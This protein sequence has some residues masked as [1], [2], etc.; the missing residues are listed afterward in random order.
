VEVSLKEDVGVDG[1][2]G[3][4]DKSGCIRDVFQNHLLQILS[5]VAMDQPKSSSANHIRDAKVNVL[6]H[7]T[8]P[9]EADEVVVGQYTENHLLP[10]YLDDDTVPEDSKTETFCQMVLYIDNERWRGVPFICR[11]GKALDEKLAQVR[12]LFQH[13]VESLYPNAPDSELV[14]RI[15][16]N[17]AIYFKINSKSPGLSSIN[18]LVKVDMNL[19]YERRFSQQVLIP[20]AY[21]R[22]ILDA[23]RGEQVLFVRADEIEQAW[24]VVDKVIKAIEK[25]RL[26]VQ[27]YMRGSSGP[28]SA[29]EVFN[30]CWKSQTYT[31]ITNVD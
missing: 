21:T 22:L 9:T 4:Y 29:E 26:K 25:G 17:K 31:K 1:R 12:I 3:Y 7:I 28:E 14:M 20:G 18:E 6:K 10:G 24:R 5:I 15:Q 30:R 19:C 23:V 8:A 13:P 2:G 16:P 11:A 27:P